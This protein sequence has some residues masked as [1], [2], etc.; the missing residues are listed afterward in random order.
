MK[1]SGAEIIIKRL[2]ECGIEQIS[3]IPGGSNLPIFDA[4]YSS[5]IKNIIPRNEQGAG[6]IAQGISRST[7]KV[8]VCMATSGPGATN[9]ITA[10]A[11]AMA[12]S[13]P[14]IAI[15]GQ[16]NSSLMGTNAFQEI[17]F[18]KMTKSICKK[19]FSIA[20]AKEL[21]SIIPEAINIAESGRPGPVVIDIPKDI[22]NEIIEIDKWP[23]INNQAINSKSTAESDCKGLDYNSSYSNTDNIKTIAKLINSS[24][25]P[26]IIAGGGAISSNATKYIAEI[27]HKNCIPIATTLMGI[28]AIPSDD[29]LCFGMIGMHGR[30]SANRLIKNADVIIALGT[31]FND[32]SASNNDFFANDAQI[33][34]IDIDPKEFGKNINS[35]F[36]IHMDIADFLEQ[37]TPLIESNNRQ[38]WIDTATKFSADDEDMYS[39]S[40]IAKTII[41]EITSN[42]I[43]SENK[44]EMIIATDVGQHQMWAAQ[45]GKYLSPRSFLTSGGIGTMGFGLPTAIGAALANPDKKIICISG[46]GSIQMNIQEFATMQEHNLNITVFIINNYQ[47]GMVTQQ[48]DI[49]YKGRKS[50]STFDNSPN[51][52]TIAEGYGIRCYD[53]KDFISTSCA[54]KTAL[55]DNAPTIVNIPFIEN[56]TVYSMFVKKEFHNKSSNEQVA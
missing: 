2:E 35:S 41:G 16:V 40:P 11:D 32:R 30:K 19:S 1:I 37:I 17:D 34:H 9:L 55:S 22:Q 25:K 6:F 21:I 15:T 14:I 45:F 31:R 48:Q 4:L 50:S 20:S 51:F 29:S 38:E 36:N 46:D 42:E 7:G 33:I 23:D 39:E 8:S 54:I 53:A 10:I 52:C 28:G 13:I 5:N 43:T 49:L 26:A 3:G 24:N 47:Y 27:S 18:A 12:D 44:Q 56:E